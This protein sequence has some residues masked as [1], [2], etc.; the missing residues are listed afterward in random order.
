ATR[1]RET[2][3]CLQPALKIDA[4]NILYLQDLYCASTQE[5]LDVI[6]DHATGANHLA[7]IAHN[8]GLE[9]LASHLTGKTFS[10]STCEA[11]QIEFFD[12]T[13]WNQISV[14]KGTVLLDLY[15]KKLDD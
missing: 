3:D 14:S 8:P 5:L 4:D 15:P 9:N 10:M 2:L 11:I 6:E 7:I 1:A 13:D 12:V